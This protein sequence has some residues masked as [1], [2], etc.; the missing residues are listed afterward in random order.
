MAIP[1]DTRSG[2]RIYVFMAAF[3]VLIALP[4]FIPDS[5]VKIAAVRAGERL[6]FPLI[7]HIHAVSMGL[8]LLVLAIVLAGIV[9][10]PTMYREVWT[11]AL[12]APPATREKLQQIVLV[13]DNILLLQLRMGVLF[14]LFMIIALR[15]RK[16]NTGLHKRMMILAVAM[17]LP[18]AI[19]RIAWLPT[20]FPTSAAAVHGLWGSEWWYAAAP[21]LVMG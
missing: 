10:V 18:P 15:A 16:A 19:D 12:N 8:F 6:P 4:G 14:P 5:F 20:T 7:L 3:F 21:R 9:L 2:S 11:A 13:R 17:V 1:M